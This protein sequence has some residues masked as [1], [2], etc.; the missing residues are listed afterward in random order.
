[1][2]YYGK[3]NN[4]LLYSKMMRFYMDREPVN[5]KLS[6]LVNSL[7]TATDAERDLIEKAL[8]LGRGR[9]QDNASDIIEGRAFNEWFKSATGKG[10][11]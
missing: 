5:Q 9:S 7:K 1:M 2:L 3:T 4:I 6:S 8:R 11:L 10:S